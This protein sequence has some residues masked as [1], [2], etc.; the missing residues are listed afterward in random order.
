MTIKDMSER[1]LSKKASQI[2]EKY[3]KLIEYALRLGD[4]QGKKYYEAAKFY[5]EKS[6]WLNWRAFGAL[7]GTSLDYFTP[8]EGRIVSFKEFMLEWVGAQF[9]RILD[10]Y[11]MERPW[12]WEYF[13]HETNWWHHAFILGFYLWRRTGNIHFRGP[14]PEERKWLNEKY[15]GWDELFGYKWDL[16][17]KSWID[18]KPPYPILPP[19]VCN[20]CGIPIF[21]Y[22]RKPVLYRLVHDG[23]IYHFDSSPCKWIFESQLSRYHGHMSYVDRILLGK[24]KL[25]PEAI[26]NP[27]V[28]WDEII[29]NMGYTEPGEAGLDPTNGGWALLYAERDP[30]YKNRIKR[31]MEEVLV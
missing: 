17:A 28:L 21:W 26:T 9:I 1:S 10:D 12:Y 8:L 19:V 23:R 3:S 14:T 7:T 16:Y 4:E 20:T 2:V 22:P 15:P 18:G 31:W 13:E 29:W 5:I 27:K 6:F 24:I 30:D 25:S 11:G